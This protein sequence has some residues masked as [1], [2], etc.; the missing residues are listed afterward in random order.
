M[1]LNR[2]QGTFELKSINNLSGITDRT[3]K[4]LQQNRF[5]IEKKDNRINFQ[6]SIQFSTN[7]GNN[8]WQVFLYNYDGVIETSNI[9]GNNYNKY[10]LN[11]NAQLFKQIILI[12]SIGLFLYQFE[13]HVNPLIYLGISVSFIL[14]QRILIKEHFLDIVAQ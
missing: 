2:I 6:R 5:I 9:N 14:I 11:I 10:S 1:W 8:R 13:T 12:L 4:R 7:T 3:V